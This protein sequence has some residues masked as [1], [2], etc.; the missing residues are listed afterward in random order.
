[1]ATTSEMWGKGRSPHALGQEG[2][3]LTV[4]AKQ[5]GSIGTADADVLALDSALAPLAEPSSNF[6]SIPS[7]T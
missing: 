5:R 7:W 3:A 6:F 1:M 2:Q 4:D